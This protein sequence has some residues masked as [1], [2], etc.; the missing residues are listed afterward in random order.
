VYVEAPTKLVSSSVCW[1]KQLFVAQLLLQAELVLGL[2]FTPLTLTA[3]LVPL[4][5]I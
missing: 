4:K 3:T 1:C 5:H 2:C